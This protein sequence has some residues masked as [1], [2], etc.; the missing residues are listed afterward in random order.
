ML[1]LPAGK[2]DVG[3]NPLGCGQRELREETGYTAEEWA[4]A[5]STHLAIG[6]ST[7]VIH[8]YFARGLKAGERSL[9]EGEFLDL[10]TMSIEAL[11]AACRDG[12]VT[13]AK[14]LSC[15]LWL[16]NVTEG[17]WSLTWQPA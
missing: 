11:L 15:C 16:Q 12:Q 10:A 5:A 7:E 9:D 3:E 13:D 8:I 2:L 6:Y 14:T 1:E 4:Y 17:R